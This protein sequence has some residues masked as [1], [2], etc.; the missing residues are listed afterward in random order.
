MT[1]DK[2]PT[3]NFNNCRDIM[4]T[5]EVVDQ[6]LNLHKK[7]YGK[8]RIARELG[9]SSRTVKRYL[10][11]QGWKPY[12]SPKKQ[13]KLAGLIE[14]LEKTFYLHKGN[15]VVVH[16]ELMRQHGI[17]VHVC[18][19]ERAVRPF[20][21]K[22]KSEAKATIRFE[23]SPGRQMQ[24]DFGTMTIKIG[25]QLQR[26]HFFAAVLGY[27]RRQYVQAFLHQRQSA[28]FEGMEGAFRHFGGV[29]DQVLLDNAKA[30]VVSHNPLTREVLFN[31]K[32]RAFASYWKFTPKACAPYRARTKGKDES[33]VKYIK[34]NAIAGRAFSS[35]EELQEHLAWWL[36]EVADSRVHGTTAEKPIIRFERDE[37]VKLQPPDGKPPFS[38]G[39]EL[40]RVVQSDAC[41]EVDSNFYSVPWPLIKKTL[42]IYVQDN[43]I[44]IFDD[45]EEVACH[46]VRYGKRERSVLN[47]HLAGIVGANWIEK[48]MGK[49]QN[50][51]AQTT[52][53]AELLR[54][55]SEY[56]AVIGG[57]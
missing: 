50:L 27:S 5:P 51:P 55:L 6:I 7:G 40:K 48:E 42:T 35:F 53:K 16:Q 4:L 12:K 25:D 32:L 9:I 15:A 45:D 8:K 49:I 13:K 54:P 39:R 17:H 11:Q 29:P 47:Q 23:T 46:A 22:L 1:C 52:Q 44:K 24:I 28:W 43:Q 36:R 18:T 31:D 10:S 56:E 57:W 30:L 37:A 33:T 20:R 2:I 38:Q 21:Q 19:V 41:V 14:W 34:K 26:V 3:N